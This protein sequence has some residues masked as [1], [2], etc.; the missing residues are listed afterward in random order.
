MN[1]ILRNRLVL[2]LI[3]ILFA[4][5]V[6]FAE[7]L[8][9]GSNIPDIK[10]P[11]L[12]DRTHYEGLGLKAVEGPFDLASVDGEMLV[13][14]LFNR[15]C[16][17]CLRQTEEVQKYFTDLG[18]KGYAGR[19]RVLAVG[20]GNDGADLKEYTRTL[21]TSFPMAADP[22]FSFYYGIGDLDSAPVTLFLRKEKGKW[23]VAD[24]HFGVQ[25]ATEMMARTKVLLAR[26]EGNPPPTV[27]VSEKRHLGLSEDEKLKYAEKALKSAGASGPA[28]KVKV[29][30]AD[31]Y[32]APAGKGG[33]G[34]LF[35]VVSKRSPVCDLC[36]DSIFAM[37]F[38]QNGQIKAFLPIYVTKYGNEAWSAQDEKFME[39][40][41][42]GL[43]SS[44]I[45][46]KSDVDA[47]TSATMSS[48]LIFD[49]ARRAGKIVVELAK[50]GR[51]R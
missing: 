23:V 6:A 32:A 2:F 19:V 15:F 4:A 33:Q 43:K 30:G 8:T 45:L 40:R 16:F 7:P 13:L 9:Q 41:L 38:D 25:G 37:V 29:K 39:A 44:D 20:I 46:F 10:A 42:V 34:S 21:K 1:S 35:A 14:E 22:S 28:A 11:A 5:A 12:V 24:L 3:P 51:A 17:S 26:K 31:V 50:G 18:N 47:V 49:E 48:S 27:Y 36:H